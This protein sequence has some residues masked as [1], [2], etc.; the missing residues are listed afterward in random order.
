MARVISA[1]EMSKHNIPE[2]V[3][4]VVDGTVYDLTEFAPEHPGGAGSE[5]SPFQMP[6]VPHL[7]PL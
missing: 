2:D 6:I 4:I 3:W 7:C 5:F 1:Q